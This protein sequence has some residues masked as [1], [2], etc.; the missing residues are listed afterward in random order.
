VSDLYPNANNQALR[1]AAVNGNL[2]KVKHLVEQSANIH[3][4]DDRAFRCAKQNKHYK[5]VKYLEAYQS[6]QKYQRIYY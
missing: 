6:T 3:V 2:Q 4:D 5:I 1:L